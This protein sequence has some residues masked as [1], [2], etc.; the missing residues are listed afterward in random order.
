MVYLKGI[1]E[2][3]TS[4][5][6]PT[7]EKTRANCPFVKLNSRAQTTETC[8]TAF[9]QVW[10]PRHHPWKRHSKGGNYNSSLLNIHIIT[11]NHKIANQKRIFAKNEAGIFLVDI[12]QMEIH[13]L[14]LFGCWLL[15]WW[16]GALPAGLWYPKLSGRKG[17]SLFWPS[18]SPVVRASIGLSWGFPLGWEGNLALPIKGLEKDEECPK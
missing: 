13:K 11:W 9:N 18:M 15:L 12:S 6:F 10:G 14:C 3:T 4:C 17:V 16:L 2:Q 5:F 8:P 1:S 7:C